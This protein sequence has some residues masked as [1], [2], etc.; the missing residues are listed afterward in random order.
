MVS[1]DKNGRNLRGLDCSGWVSWVYW[2]ALGQHLQYES[3]SGLISL[4]NAVKRQD[5]KPGDIIVGDGDGI[6][7]IDP[8]DAEALA[9]AT[10]KTMEKEAKIME[11]I[12]H[13]GEY[14]RPWVDEKLK[15]IGCDF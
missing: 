13:K 4:G 1:P 14:I 11:N 10:C 5:L 7:I 6:V 8:V 2:T 15:E 9:A 12:I 3:T